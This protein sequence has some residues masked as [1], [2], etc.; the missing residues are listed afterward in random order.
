MPID[1][2]DLYSPDEIDA[3]ANATG[4]FLNRLK[5]QDDAREQ[6][7]A[8]EAAVE[9]KAT[10]ELA[11]PREKENWG[12]AAFAKEGQSILSGG[13]QDTASSLTTFP[14]RTID[15]LSGE[16]AKERKEKGFYRPEWDPFVDYD[17]PITTKTWWGKLL[18]GTVHFGTMAA[19]IIPAGKAFLAKTG[20]QLT[21]MAA[22]QIGKAALIGGT[23]DLVSKESDGHNALGAIRERYGFIDTPLTTKDTDHPVM[24]KLKNI[25]E[26][27]GIGVAFDGVLYMVKGGSDRAIQSIKNR[28]DRVQQ[29]DIDKSV[30]EVRKAVATKQD[31]FRAAKNRPVADA[32]QGTVLSEAD[33]VYDAHVRS[34][35][36]DGQEGSAGGVI[37]PVLIERVAR[38]AVID[39]AMA[40]ATLKKLYSSD[41]YN[42]IIEQLKAEQLT[43]AE[44]YGD[45]IMAYQRITKGRDAAEMTADEFLGELYASRDS[46]DVTDPGGNV[47]DNIETFTSKNIVVA[48]MVIGSLLHDIRNRGIAGREL[49]NMV[50]LGD[51]DGPAAQIV[52]TMMTALTEVRKARIIKSENFRQIGAGKRRQYLQQE[53]TKEMADTK[54]AMMT[55]LKIAKDDADPKLLNALFEVWS[56]MKSVNNL[57]DWD[58]WSRAMLKGGSLHKGGPKR[59]GVLISELGNMFSNSILSGPKTPA[60]AVMGTA[61]ATFLRPMATTLGATM[62]YPFTGDSATVRASLASMN[63]MMDAIPESFTIFKERLNSYWSGD[64]STIKSRYSEY[65]R[66]DDNWEILRRWAEESGRATPADRATFYMANMARNWNN[67]SF[68]TW[69]PKVMAATDDAFAHILGRS[70]AREMAMREVL[71]VQGAG[72]RLPVINRQVMQAYEQDFYDRIWNADGTIKDEATKW[73]RQEVTLTTPMSGFSKGLGDVFAANPWAKPFFL[74]ART[75]VSGLNLSAKHTPGFNFLVKEF[76]D[77]ARATP[78]NLDEVAQYGITNATELANAKALQTGRLGMGA[79]LISMVSWA[80]MSGNITGNGPVDRQKR[81]MWIDAG[82]RPRQFK[83]GG[84]WVGY[85]SIEPFNQI[86]AITADIGDASLLMGDEW[87]EQ[88]LLKMSLVVAQGVT[89]KSY[90]SGLSQLVDLVAGKPG[91]QNRILAGI[92]N[93]QVPMA[94]LRNELG[95]LFNPHMKE[96]SSGIGDSIRNRNL[97]SEYLPGDDLP[98]KYD[99]LNGKPIRD[100]DFMT[101]AFNMFSPI[102]LNLDYSAGRQ[103]LFDSGYDVRM[104]TYF[105]PMG[106]DL[107][108]SPRIRSMFQKAIGETNLERKLEKLSEDPRIQASMDEMYSDIRGGKRGDY[109][110]SD[111]FHNLKIDQVFQNARKAAWAKIMKD[112]RI[113]Q[114]RSQQ[115]NIK[116]RKLIKKQETTNILSLPK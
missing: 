1:P 107:S 15:A 103:L 62:R 68:L 80:W 22:T 84:V 76:N 96:L 67:N 90:F 5:E 79:S 28:N 38:E 55:I 81:Q 114:L 10:A 27:M 92:M 46:Y 21:G 111:Y 69:S 74:F 33:D 57:D 11:D 99:M 44:V 30:A 9:E 87:T 77:I 59:T 102:S 45:S 43:V 98:T 18:R 50:D 3:A 73:A 106:D 48:D 75:G 115:I 112:P 47:V 100:Y 34:R 71:D 7:A 2:N 110:T 49:A 20:I 37:P 113:Q 13:I 109:E 104:S 36:W 51:I 35:D 70:K 26:G 94:G 58:A 61:T 60:R 17:D 24:M 4:E 32:H 89:S 39:N 85:E 31:E 12:V 116:R 23:S 105:S 88:Q 8:E 83:I 14:E 56:S 95:K 64:I 40:E 101:R 82:Y 25:L 86:M 41:R 53:L 42:G 97:I 108:D 52:D 19:A 65:S 16:M 78:K 6:V 91:Q 72:G 93:N 29:A 63:A 66:N 54:D